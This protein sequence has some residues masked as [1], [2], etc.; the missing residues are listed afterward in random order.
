VVLYQD[1]GCTTP[2]ELACADATFAG[3]TESLNITTLTAGNTYRVR[4]YDKNAGATGTFNI[5]AT[6]VP[7]APLN[8]NCGGAFTLTP[9][10]SCT[11][12]AGT[13]EAATPSPQAT[14]CS[15]DP[16]DDV[17]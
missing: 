6:Y 1:N 8:D 16:D 10:S 13:A 9:G 7:N 4:V 17:W 2:A 15:G 3:G 14:A 12:T 11:I 5:C